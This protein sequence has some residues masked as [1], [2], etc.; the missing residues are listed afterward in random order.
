MDSEDGGYF[1]RTTNGTGATGTPTFVH[2]NEGLEQ[3]IQDNHDDSDNDDTDGDAIEE[4]VASDFDEEKGM[5]SPRLLRE[6]IARSRRHQP[7]VP[8]DVAPY[9]VEAYVSLRM[10]DRPGKKTPQKAGAGG[11]QTVMTARQL[12]SILRLSQALAR[13]RF[14]DF[15]AREDVDE[16]IRLTHMSKASLTEQQESQNGKREDVMSRVFNILRDYATAS[17]STSVE[18]KLAEAM[19]LRKG[20]TGQQLQSC[21]EEYEALEI[22]QVNQNQT[23]LHFVT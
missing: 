9:I 20:F 7:M 17:Q 18:L 11:D 16:A 10:Q 12:L 23:H 13:L 19:V 2:Q 1:A 14:S 6:Y 5:V 22:L 8:V 21:L 15:V 3:Q 4:D